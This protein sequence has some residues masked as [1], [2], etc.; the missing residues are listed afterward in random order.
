MTFDAE[1]CE[2]LAEHSSKTGH[3]RLVSRGMDKLTVQ[4]NLGAS[5][6][7][8]WFAWGHPTRFQTALFI[9][10]ECCQQDDVVVPLKG[11]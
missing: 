3:A 2:L 11:L 7:R 4:S 8:H 5:P 6:L 1:A 9:E 10:G